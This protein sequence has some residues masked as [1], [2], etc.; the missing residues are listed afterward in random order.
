MT[1]LPSKTGAVLLDFAVLK[2]ISNRK[3]GSSLGNSETQGYKTGISK[4]GFYMNIATKGISVTKFLLY[5]EAG[6]DVLFFFCFIVCL[7][8]K[9]QLQRHA[10]LTEEELSEKF[11]YVRT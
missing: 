4:S 1:E 7:H 9:I 5:R 8:Y 10:H 2:S 3:S 11:I 6:R